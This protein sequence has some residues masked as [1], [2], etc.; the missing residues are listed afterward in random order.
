MAAVASTARARESTVADLAGVRAPSPRPG[1]AITVVLLLAILYAAFAHGATALG[2]E[3]RVQIVLALAAAVACGAWLWHGGLRLAAAPWAWAGLALLTGFAVWSGI[4][5]D[6]SIA[7]ART[8]IEL[9]RAVAY[10]LV[11]ALALAA[12]AWDA[13]A[14]RRLALGY[15]AVAMLVSLYA[16]GGKLVPGLHIPGIIN[17]NH[18]SHISRLRAPL[19]Y[20]NALALFCVMA[21]PIALRLAV[22]VS[23]PRSWRLAGLVCLALLAVTIG[24]T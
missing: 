4:T 6:W 5:L 17:L 23:R 8:W 14:P 9:N 20:W 10:V 3:A 13:R 12:G 7:P 2:D 19:D 1:A 21:V 16:L 15:L 24:L 22:E 18:T 11:V